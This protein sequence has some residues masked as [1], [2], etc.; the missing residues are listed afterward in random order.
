MSGE[1]AYGDYPFEATM[2]MG[3]IMQQTETVRDELVH[4]SA[5]PK[6]SGKVYALAKKIASEASKKKIKAILVASANPELSRALASYRP[7]ALVVPVGLSE[8]DVRELMLA[9]AVRPS[10]E[11]TLVL[12]SHELQKSGFVGADK[13]TIVSEKKGKYQ[14]KI[15][16]LKSIKA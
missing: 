15:V 5:V 13:V 16:T 3:R 1:T 8:Q 9:Y 10:A 14:S 6:V 2:T 4:F 12:A 11:P 7:T